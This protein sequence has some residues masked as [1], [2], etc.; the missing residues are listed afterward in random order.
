MASVKRIK[1]SFSLN[2]CVILPNIN[3]V[4]TSLWS[5]EPLIACGT[6]L[7]RVLVHVGNICSNYL[8]RNMLACQHLSKNK[9]WVSHGFSWIF[10]VF[11]WVFIGFHGSSWIFMVYHGFSWVYMGFHGF[12]S[13]IEKFWWEKFRPFDVTMGD[14]K[15]QN[16]SFHRK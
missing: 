11:S 4:D 8:V 2:H 9:P 15:S 12:P 1:D 10:M 6:F 3:S 7:C 5:D 13:L 14:E 16:P